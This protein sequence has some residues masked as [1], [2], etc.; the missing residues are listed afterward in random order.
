VVLF[1][2]TFNRYFEP[3][4]LS[5]AERVLRA[6]GYRLHRPPVQGRPLCCG[7]TF[8]ASGQVDQARAEAQR[9][10]DA[11]LTLVERGARVVGLEP[12]CLLTLRDEFHALLPGVETQK[13]S[14]AALLIEE[15]LAQDT[16]AGRV[17]LDLTDAGSRV[18]HLHGHCHQKS[19][20]AMGSV[21]QVLRLVPGLEVKPIES[22]C[23]GMAGA[24]GHQAETLQI[25]R[26]MGELAL[27]PA[28]RAAET[29]DW[30][31]ADGTSCRAQILDGTGRQARHVVRVLDDCLKGPR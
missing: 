19:F 11:L 22:G 1:G 12:S 21:G 28:V 2:D 7:R 3:E 10:R 29:Q 14:D 5:A 20:G 8:L 23:C 17:A 6:A 13:L 27:L 18:A 4:N 9:T 25:S 26:A 16:A 24:F 31:V 15:A 30:I